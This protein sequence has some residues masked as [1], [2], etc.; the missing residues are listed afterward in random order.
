M[1]TSFKCHGFDSRR[2]QWRTFYNGFLNFLRS[3]M[4]SAESSDFYGHVSRKQFK[5][6]K[7]WA[8]YIDQ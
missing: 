5:F 8:E 3:I 2:F 6:R 7:E 1:A 4:I